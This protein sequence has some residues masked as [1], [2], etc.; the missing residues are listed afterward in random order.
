MRIAGGAGP[1]R[2]AQ[3]RAEK[4]AASSSFAISQFLRAKSHSGPAC[5]ARASREAGAM[6]RPPLVLLLSC[7]CL[8]GVRAEPLAP[9]SRPAGATMFTLMAPEATGVVTE[10]RYADPRIWME[11]YHE[12]A[13]GAIGTGV[14]VGDYDG[15]GRPDIFVVSKTETCRL[16]RNL[17]GWKFEDVTERAGLVQTGEAAREWKQGAAFADVDNDGRLDLYV[18][19]HAAP[20]LL[21]L[22][23]GDGTF[24]EEAAARGLALNDASGMGAFCDYDRDGWLD[25][26]VQTNILDVNARPSG[27]RD[28][29]FHNDGGGRF[30][31]VTDRAGLRGESQGHSATWWDYDED[32][33]PDLYIAN[34][35]LVPDVLWRNR[36][37]GTFVNVIDEVVPVMPYH[38]MGAD[39]G[40]FDGDGRLD[41]FVADMARTTSTRE[42]A[43]IADSRARSRVATP[44]GAAP[45]VMR[46]T[47]FL[48]TGTGRCLEAG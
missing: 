37:D 44:P 14:A 8:S 12:F 27:Q 23:Q 16:F 39:V 7:L 4:T 29:L 31:E 5:R 19:R 41:L 13:I 21:Y 11:R 22:N 3:L 28:R 9:R 42:R 25:V 24:R 35:F 6:R 40:D 48:A 30:S 36:G 18:C 17:G 34:D 2:G 1:G 26:L 46:N 15:D 32:G 43:T 45:Q 38:S 10:N 33:L 20:N 47:L